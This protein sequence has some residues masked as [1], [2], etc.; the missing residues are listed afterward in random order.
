MND[1]IRLLFDDG[2][3]RKPVVHRT[4]DEFT[5][6]LGEKTWRVI[7]LTAE[8]CA[9]YMSCDWSFYKSG[10]RVEH[11]QNID[12]FKANLDTEPVRLWGGSMHPGWRHNSTPI[13][14]AYNDIIFVRFE[15]VL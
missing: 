6:M 1:F 8:E 2:A 12:N 15:E 4:G 7:P 3:S 14:G 9:R 11:S 13:T 5:F 10:H